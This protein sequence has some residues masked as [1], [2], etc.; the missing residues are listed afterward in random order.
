MSGDVASVDVATKKNLDELVK[1]GEGLLKK[2]VSRVNLQTG[3]Y[4][5]ANHETNEEAL[6]RY[7]LNSWSL[8]QL[9]FIFFCKRFIIIQKVKKLNNKKY[10]IIFI[11]W[12]K[13]AG[14]RKFFL[15]RSVFVMQDHPMDDLLFLHQ[16]PID[17]NY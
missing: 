14:L 11:L 7:V 16:I 12:L 6:T 8:I 4:E 15:K 5:T 17:I 9:N 1:V 10:Y 13:F 3:M 2:P